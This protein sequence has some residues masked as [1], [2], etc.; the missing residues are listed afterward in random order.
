[1]L[2]VPFNQQVVLKAAATKFMK[3]VL[4]IYQT[5]APIKIKVKIKEE[6]LMLSVDRRVQVL[7]GSSLA[8]EDN[9]TTITIKTKA[10]LF[11]VCANFDISRRQDNNDKYLFKDA[12]R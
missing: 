9:K 4:S 8:S 10:T 5:L 3:M 1:M 7:Q 12:I 6:A 11:Q 2:S